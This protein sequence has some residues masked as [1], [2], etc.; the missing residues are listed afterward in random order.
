[1]LQNV[2]KKWMYVTKTE[3]WNLIK[4]FVNESVTWVDRFLMR[5]LMEE[6]LLVF[7]VSQVPKFHRVVDWGRRQQPITT[8][9]ELRMGHF[10]FMQLVAEN[11]QIKLKI[12]IHT[13]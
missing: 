13:F 3:R 4:S 1:M 7:E 6:A 5:H 9:V 10:G 12:K 8:G 11:L 2:L